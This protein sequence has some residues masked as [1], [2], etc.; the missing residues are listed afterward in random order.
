[1][2]LDVL[3]ALTAALEVT[4]KLGR[5]AGY[6]LYR[7]GWHATATL[8]VFGAAVGACKIF[9]LDAERTA[10]ALGIAASRAC[11][12]RA[13]IGTMVKPFHCGFAAR[14]GLEAALL[15]AATATASPHALDGPAGFLNTFA[16][17]HDRA[18][19][20]AA[21]LGNPFEHREP[22]IVFKKYPSC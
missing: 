5:A 13:N 6:E 9:R 16:P 19:D 22:G 12:L 18:V 8:G 10:V 7:A 3:I 2:G 14:D 21:L 11:G 17:K 15:A 1:P 20:V 4:T